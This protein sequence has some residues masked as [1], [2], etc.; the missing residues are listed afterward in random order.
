MANNKFRE[1]YTDALSCY[2]R[3]QE[4]AGLDIVTDGDCRFDQDV[5]G[6]DEIQ[7]GVPSRVGFEIDGDRH[8]IAVAGRSGA[9]GA[10]ALHPDDLGAE[11]AEVTRWTATEAP[12]S[13]TGTVID[14]NGA[15]YVR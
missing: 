9:T 6:R 13:A 7:H 10:L 2:L 14:V 3:D 1:Q 4:V 8:P 12:P 5:G 11:V 15:S